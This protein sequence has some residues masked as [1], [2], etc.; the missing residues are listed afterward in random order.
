MFFHYYFLLFAL[1][2]SAVSLFTMNLDVPKKNDH[3][4][5]SQEEIARDEFE[6]AMWNGDRAKLEEI[7][8]AGFNINKQNSFGQSYLHVTYTAL[9]SFPKERKKAMSLMDL[10][11]NQKIKD[12]N[13]KTFI[14]D[15]SCQ[16]EVNIPMA[17]NNGNLHAN[18]NGCYLLGLCEL[19][20]HEMAVRALQSFI[21]SGKS[22]HKQC[23]LG[24]DRE[25]YFC[26]YEQRGKCTPLQRALK[27]GNGPLAELLLE[28]G[29]D[30][31]AVDCRYNTALDYACEDGDAQRVKILA[32]RGADLMVPVNNGK[33]ASYTLIKNPGKMRE[34]LATEPLF[35]ISTLGRLFDGHNEPKSTMAAVLPAEITNIIKRNYLQ[36]CSS[37]IVVKLSSAEAQ[38]W[39]GAG[40]DGA[41]LKALFCFGKK[42]TKLAMNKALSAPIKRY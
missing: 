39:R 34:D 12:N 20:D 23:C 5:L 17:D 1:F 35:N 27:V 25:T 4:V 30:M 10:G 11:V 2:S 14:Y 33:P 36:A 28:N 24:R 9:G 8:G 37:A 42:E 21:K 38:L 6:D 16:W 26:R 40:Y 3:R 32:G 31:N 18:N 13:N 29:A 15:M 22:I 7:K 41:P 19:K